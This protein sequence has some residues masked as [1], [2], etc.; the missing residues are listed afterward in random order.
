M[1]TTGDISYED[2]TTRT[3]LND[4][5]GINIKINV[6]R[7]YGITEELLKILYNKLNFGGTFHKENELA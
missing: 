5:N 3:P 4:F 1:L 2:S 7:E 6:L